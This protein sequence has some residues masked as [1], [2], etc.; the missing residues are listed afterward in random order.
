MGISK[1]LEN[2]LIPDQCSFRTVKSRVQTETRSS[3]EQEHKLKIDEFVLNDYRL[4]QIK[5]L[6]QELKLIQQQPVLEDDH[7]DDVDDVDTNNDLENIQ[8]LIVNMRG[9]YNKEHTTMIEYLLNLSSFL[10]DPTNNFVDACD[11]PPK[12]SSP[13]PE[14]D[15]GQGKNNNTSSHRHQKTRLGDV[16]QGHGGRRVG[17][18]SGG[19]ISMM[20]SPA[21]STRLKS[22]NSSASNTIES[23]GA[24]EYGNN[25][26]RGHRFKKYVSEVCNNEALPEQTNEEVWCNV[27]NASRVYDPATCSLICPECGDS[28]Q[29]IDFS[30]NNYNIYT[31]DTIQHISPYEYKRINHLNDWMASFQGCESVI[32]SNDIIIL[33][34]DEIRKQRL[35]K[36]SLKTKDIKQ[37]LKKCGLSRYY[38]HS[39]SILSRVTNKKPIMLPPNLQEQ[40]RVMFIQAE[41]TF[42]R[43]NNRQKGNRSN[44]L[45]YSLIISS[46]LRILGRD[47]LASQFTVLKSRTK[48]IHQMSVWKTIC[49]EN[50][51]P[52]NPLV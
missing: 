22:F 47:D 45:S 25:D 6:E 42:V 41:Q 12:Y 49:T 33:I 3:I 20:M 51:W 21:A 31:D 43:L 39:N 14:E 34:N 18:T 15:N 24:V 50:N 44:F 5:C 8:E 32:I 29:F 23:F 9:V 30:Q 2:Q 27:C 36:N 52:Y 7:D 48:L 4:Q 40:I 38:E 16:L 13:P 17:N 19:S 26:N 37:I 46:I 28:H 10:R 11:L 35:N 1:R